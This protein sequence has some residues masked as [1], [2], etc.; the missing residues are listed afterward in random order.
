VDIDETEPIFCNEAKAVA[1][2]EAT[3]WP[4][5]TRCPLCHSRNVR[6]MQGQTQPGM[7]LCN[8]CRRKFTVRTGTVFERSHIPVHKWLLAV[9][10][11]LEL[12]LTV[13]AMPL[14]RILKLKSYRSAWHMWH[15]IRD[16]IRLSNVRLNSKD[17][18][19][20]QEN[21]H[22]RE[23]VLKRMLLTVHQ[24]HKPIGKT[25]GNRGSGAIRPNQAKPNP[26]PWPAD[27]NRSPNSTSQQRLG[28]N[29]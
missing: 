6:R 8:D 24:P 1:Y 26:L 17:E 29:K 21:V 5:G 20:H 18:Y 16:S 28:I 9:H 23:T 13:G 10:R 4:D 12:N 22:Q 11:M 19:R 14:Q 27:R 25:L 15:R 2:L 3:R 7:F